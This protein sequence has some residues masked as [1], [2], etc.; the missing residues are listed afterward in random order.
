MSVLGDSSTHFS[1]IFQPELFFSFLTS[2]MESDND[3]SSTTTSSNNNNNE[4]VM[5]SSQDGELTEI[6]YPRKHGK[7]EEKRL[8]VPPSSARKNL[9]PGVAFSIF[10]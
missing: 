5:P 7:Y 9:S 4:D 6:R 10:H 3:P 1:Q 8:L 2:K